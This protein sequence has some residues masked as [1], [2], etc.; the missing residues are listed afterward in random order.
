MPR[1]AVVRHQ[2]RGRQ[3][4][5]CPSHSAVPLRLP[6]CRQVSRMHV[7]PVLSVVGIHADHDR[8]TGVVRR[9]APTA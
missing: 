2:P 9:F 4:G 3:R 1:R 5:R 8:R 7:S 6:G